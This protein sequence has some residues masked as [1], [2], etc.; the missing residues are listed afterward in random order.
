M[1]P[2]ENILPTKYRGYTI[3]NVT[4]PDWKS[5]GMHVQF[6][7]PDGEIVMHAETIGDAMEMIDGEPLDNYL[8]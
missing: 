1:I 4:D 6:F 5:V 8:E 3:E 2:N 7:W